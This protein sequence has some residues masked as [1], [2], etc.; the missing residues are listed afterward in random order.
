[1]HVNPPYKKNVPSLQKGR[2]LRGTTF[3]L[4]QTNVSTLFPVNVRLTEQPLSHSTVQ[5]PGTFTFTCSVCSHRPQTLFKNFFKITT[6]VHCCL[7][8]VLLIIT[9]IFVLCNMFPKIFRSFSFVSIQSGKSLVVF[10]ITVNFCIR[11]QA[12]KNRNLDTFCQQ[13]LC[14]QYAERLNDKRIG[15]R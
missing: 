6:P 1:M 2:K 5:L 7:V 13:I 8:M 4:I 10:I 9:N 15:N 14:T 3:I 11:I 12:F